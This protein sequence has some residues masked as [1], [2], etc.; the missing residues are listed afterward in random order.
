MPRRIKF[1]LSILSLS[2][3]AN[4][5]QGQETAADPIV[6]H[7]CDFFR[8][9]SGQALVGSFAPAISVLNQTN[10][11][12]QYFVTTISL[13]LDA[14]PMHTPVQLMNRSNN[15]FG[16][17]VETYQGGEFELEL[18]YVDDGKKLIAGSIREGSLEA[19]CSWPL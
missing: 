3:I 4:L 6:L 17:I 2:M 7:Q 18:M 14:Q 15:A 8:N 16:T 19:G 11:T 13:T 10:G 12:I 1:L 5:A 9:S